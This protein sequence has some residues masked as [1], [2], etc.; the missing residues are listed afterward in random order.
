MEG[1]LDGV[2]E[3]KS[4]VPT[5]AGEWN[6]FQLT[7]RGDTASLKVNGQPSWEVKGIE[8]PR[9]R[10]ALQ[11]EIPGGGQFLFRNI[12]ITDLKKK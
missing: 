11:A 9:G 3:G 8:T 10:L 5:K 6:S 1:D 4:H 2:K 12:R 7:V